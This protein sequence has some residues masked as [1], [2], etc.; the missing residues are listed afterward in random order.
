MPAVTIGLVGAGFLA[1]TRA[2][3][4][5]ACRGIVAEIAAVAAHRSERAQAF[6]QRWSVPRVYPDY[7]ALLADP[8]IDLI[9]VCAPNALHAEIVIAAARAGK[10]IICTKPLTGY[11]GGASDTPRVGETPKRLMYDAAMREA[12]AMVDA[13]EAA[14]VKLMYAENWVYAPAIQRARALMEAGGGTVLEMRGGECHSGSHAPSSRQWRQSGGGSLI[15]LAAHPVG[16][17]LY[18]KRVEGIRRAGRPIEPASVVADVGNLSAIGAPG[19]APGGYFRTDWE[20]VEDWGTI[21]LT[22]TDGTK[23]V[24]SG[25][26]VQLGGMQSHL[27]LS[28]SNGR[29]LCQL[30]PTDLC[31][32]YA[33]NGAVWGDTYLMEKLET[34]AG[35][36]AP[37]PDEPWAHGHV[38]QI[39]DFVEA[40]AYDRALLS[41]GHLGRAVVQVIYAAYIA[42]E[43][44]RRVNLPDQ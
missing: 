25:S 13:A 27:E 22:F 6:A 17:A 24:L 34:G 4:Y 11:F 19:D 37:A 28:L 26:D 5:A 8:A 2:R 31:R 21:L 12:T 7:Q 16:A 40:V 14:G 33:P 32:A 3:C 44:G 18:L 15:R 42:A 9:D 30:S 20:D 35:W 41:D 23:A 10:H 36:S 1:E 38:Q 39:Q 29:I 43:E